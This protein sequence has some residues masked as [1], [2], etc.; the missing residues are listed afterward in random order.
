MFTE[1]NE[2]RWEHHSG[3]LY[4]TREDGV[5]GGLPG[6]LFPLSRREEQELQKA[7]LALGMGIVALVFRAFWG[8]SRP[9]GEACLWGLG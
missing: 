4:S 5:S 6:N 1:E 3:H 2:E 9:A 8:N 7:L